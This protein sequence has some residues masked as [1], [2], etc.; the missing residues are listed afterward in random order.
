ME[1]EGRRMEGRM[2]GREKVEG[3]GDGLRHGGSGMDAPGWQVLQYGRLLIFV[4]ECEIYLSGEAYEVH[5][6]NVK[7]SAQY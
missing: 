6:F 3:L 2:G 1:M 7:K 5:R 4:V